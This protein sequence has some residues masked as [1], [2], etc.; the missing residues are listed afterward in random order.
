MHKLFLFPLFTCIVSCSLINVDTDSNHGSA[1]LDPEEL[2]ASDRLSYRYKNEI[3]NDDKKNI[4]NKS[5]VIRHKTVKTK[6]D[7][8]E[9]FKAL[10]HQK[11]LESEDYKS[12]KEWQE[13]QDWLDYKRSKK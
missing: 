6:K 4:T 2:Y 7:D 13:F 3:L 10:R 1:S 11:K 5:T 12:F 9:L 8:F